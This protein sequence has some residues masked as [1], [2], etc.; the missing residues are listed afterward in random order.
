MIDIKSIKTL[1]WKLEIW[2]MDGHL[3]KMANKT[4]K[5]AM[6]TEMPRFGTYCRT[7]LLNQ[8]VLSKT[9]TVG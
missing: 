3:Y 5:G 9:Y 8:T 4:T 6:K 1:R 7:Q 2:K